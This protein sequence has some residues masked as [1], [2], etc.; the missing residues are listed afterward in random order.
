MPFARNYNEHSSD[1]ILAYAR[2][3]EN[4]NLHQL[5]SDDVELQTVK[6]KGSFGIL[7]EKYYF[8][9]EPNSNP[10]PDF[11]NNNV[12][13]ELKSSPLHELKNGEL[14]VKERL[15]L[16][17]IN[18]HKI[19]EETFEKSSFISKNISLL[20]VFYIWKKNT[21]PMLLRIKK[22]GLWK[23]P[24]SDKLI[25]KEDW[26]LIQSKIKNGK[27]HELSEGDTIY[28]GACTKGST[29]V[30]SKTS[31]PCS[32]ILAKR[33]AFSYKTSYVNFIYSQISTETS[34]FDNIIR[35]P[36]DLIEN[37]FESLIQK[38]FNPYFGMTT[39]EIEQKLGVVLNKNNKSYYA[40][41]TNEILGIS[42]SKKP[43]EFEKA[44]ILFRTIRIE[45]NEKIKQS[46]SFTPFKFNNIYDNEWED[47]EIRET[48][49][50][51]FFFVFYKSDGE[52]FRLSKTLFWNMNIEELK[53]FEDIY[54]RTRKVIQ[55]GRIVKEIKNG[56]TLNNFPKIKDSFLGH[57]RPHA[58]NKHDVLPLPVPDILSKKDT[59]TKQSFWLN[60]HFILK[61][62]LDS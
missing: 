51:K 46:I 31:Q 3:L 35:N 34:D 36:Q 33:R 59:F 54:N 7:L 27:A 55:E 26:I 53:E 49:E 38:K 62:Y 28:L 61:L 42:S 5:L 48:I 18:Y 44:N 56:K 16:G 40:Q 39:D 17:M 12:S 57:V 43:A 58:K 32:E 15:V 19:I 9:Y 23:I 8:G 52:S 4:H 13:L 25:I 20:L 50:R 29:A 47:S 45:K 24:D 60:N 2:K 30:K 22:V 37:N 6:G 10:T 1:S 41:L 21:S 11:S 14:R